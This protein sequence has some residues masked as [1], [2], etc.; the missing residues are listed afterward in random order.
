MHHIMYTTQAA[1][2]I[3]K[4]TSTVFMLKM[5]KETNTSL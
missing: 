1:S 3:D 5:E 2:I 4:R